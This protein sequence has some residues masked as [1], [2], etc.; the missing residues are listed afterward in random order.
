MENRYLRLNWES[1]LPKYNAKG[2][3]SGPDK[4]AYAEEVF[5]QVNRLMEL[6]NKQHDRA[7]ALTVASFA[8][9]CLG[10]LLRTFFRD[11]KAAEDLLEGFNAPL[12]TF[13]ARAKVCH[14]MGLLSDIQ[15][16]DLELIRK[17]RNEF[18]HT[19]D[20]CSF[21]DEKIKGWV[22]SLSPPRISR[23]SPKSH[24]AKFRS[25]MF[26]ILVEA[27]VLQSKIE[28]ENKRLS[29]IAMHLGSSKKVAH[30]RSNTKD[31]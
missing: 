18:A 9:E 14:A 15:F 17:I 25:S 2:D 11:V 23:D 19:W 4:I 28:S 10:R 29:P 1:G 16:K 26:G 20:E 22:N 6:A 24:E 3:V 7:L 21:D 31:E 30:S 5:G 12:G 8:E 13:A 27:E